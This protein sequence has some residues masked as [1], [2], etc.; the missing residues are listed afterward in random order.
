M[1]RARPLAGILA[2]FR[3]RAALGL[4][5]AAAPVMLFIPLGILLGPRATG[6]VSEETLAHMDVVISIALATLGVLIGVAA[7]REGAAVPRLFTASS[8]E[9]AITVAVVA[10]AS[11]LLM[12]AW[13]LPLPV[14]H[15]FMAVALGVCAAASAAPAVDEDAAP[16]HRVAAYVADL[17]DVLP[18]ALGGV[19][20]V[21]WAA[22]GSRTAVSLL[23]SVSSGAGIAI[24]GWLLIEHSEGAERGVFV[25]GTLAFLGGTAAY[26]STSP[27]LAG[28]VAG[29]LWVILPG[30]ADRV[31]GGDLR[32]VQ[33]PLIVLVLIA[34]G[35]GLQVTTVGT[36]LFAVYV[37]FRLAGKVLGGW[38]ASRIVPSIAPADLGAYLVPPGVI[39]I[40]F[41]LNLQ[42]VRSD[43][44][45]A[46]VFAVAAGAIASEVL[47]LAVTPRP[48][49]S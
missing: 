7:G 35:A 25:L 41:A 1:T 36:W 22:T 34:A 37:G 24:G 4:G 12:G 39:G 19:V 6:I 40:A 30:H 42:Q 47:S 21:L 38:M 5:P 43:A 32:K 28:L 14:P 29:W 9:A 15:L 2:L 27:L 48:R 8:A 33:H 16:S 46:L 23:L 3:T 11:L 20:L 31:I 26:L 13:R 45:T 44:G 17:D 18:I 49:R 10:G